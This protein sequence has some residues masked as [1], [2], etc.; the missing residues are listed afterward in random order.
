MASPNDLAREIEKSV[1]DFNSAIPKIQ[2]QILIDIEELI[3]N[4]D[5]KNGNLKV[6]VRNL[7]IVGSVKSKI[8]S[9]I[10]KNKGYKERLKDFIK[11]FDTITL[12]QNRYF[13]SLSKEYTPPKLL[14]E[15]RQQAKEATYE[16]LT[17]AGISQSISKPIQDILKVNITSGAR[18]TDL[19]TNLRDFITTNKLGNGVLESHVKQITTDTL[20]TY[21]RTYSDIVTNDLNLN[22][23]QYTGAIIE[24]SRPF[25]VAMH[26]KR[27]F[28][29]SEI[30]DLLKGNFPEFKEADGKINP[31]ND[32]PY[33]LK[34][35][36]TPEN[37][38]TLAGG[39]QCAHIPTPVS[40]LA[41]PESLREQFPL[42]TS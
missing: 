14:K 6:N 36:T 33:G 8:E 39:H 34:N 42:V 10:L 13:E 30:P 2:R 11:S 35:E 32:L 22:W 19:V 23:H 16:S 41:V 27:Y 4:L 1:N 15:I 40:D 31:R 5:V 37:F 21:A 18:Y 25:C 7:K 9:L 28:H 38:L 29:K 26:K 12:A 20:N 17:K 24:T 3:K